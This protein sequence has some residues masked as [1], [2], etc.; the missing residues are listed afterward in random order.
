MNISALQKVRY[1]YKPK[2]PEN[3]NGS[4]DS[5]SIQNGEPTESISDKD[6]LR[7]IFK[8]TYGKPIVTFVKGAND[9]IKRELKVGVILSGGQA[10]GGHNV[11]AGLYDGLKKG[12]PNSTLYGFKGRPSGLTDNKTIV[13][14]DAIIDEY[15]NTGG[16]DIIGSGRTKIETPD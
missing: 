14:T 9:K 2:L 5:I 16:F 8:N 6:E 10:P 7:G 3:L 12:N 13:L 11:I 1:E 4:I 15:R